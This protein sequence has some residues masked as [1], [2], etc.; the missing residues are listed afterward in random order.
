MHDS[1]LD[2][3]LAPAVKTFSLLEKDWPGY[4]LLATHRNSM[5]YSIL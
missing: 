2:G 5:Q 3:A 1:K 4:Y